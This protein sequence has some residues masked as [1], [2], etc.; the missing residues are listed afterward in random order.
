MLL[1][2]VAALRAVLIPG[3]AGIMCSAPLQWPRLR[4][5]GRTAPGAVAEQPALLRTA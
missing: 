1:G 3:E 5:R 2:T 4:L